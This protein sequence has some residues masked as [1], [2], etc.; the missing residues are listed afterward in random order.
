MADLQSRIAALPAEK[1]ALLERRLAEMA[2]AR[3][4][5]P[6]DR[7]KPR[8]RSKPTP[9][10]IPQEREW[11]VGRFRSANNIPGAFR[12]VGEIDPELLSQVFTE[13]IRRH[14]VLRSTVEIR[15]GGSL[16]QV[17]HP[18]TPVPVPV[19]DLTHLTPEQQAQQVRRRW[20]AEVV[21]RFGPGQPQ[22]LRISLLRMAENNHVA[23]VTTDHAA[24]D[25][26]SV[27]LLI[28]EFAAL[29]GIHAHGGAQSLPP[30]EIQY[31]D[32]AAWQR[33]LGHERMAAE[34][35]FWRRS[36]DGIRD[37]LA[38]P[39]DRPFPARPTFAGDVHVMDLSPELA[40]ELRRFG[41][42][43]KV[44]VGVLLLAA[45]AVLLHRYLDQT[46]LII[47]ELVSGRNRVETERLIGCFNNALPLRIRLNGEQTLREV[48]R[49]VRDVVMSSYDNQDLS[50]ERL[51]GE[52]A[53][54]HDA[55][56]TSMTD[57]WLNV[58]TLP[59]TLEVPGL[60]VSQEPIDVTLTA[61]PLMLEADPGAGALDLRWVY[62]TEMFDTDTVALF[63]E[64]YQR[65]LRQLVT[66]ADIPVGQVELAV[67]EQPSAAADP[68]TDPD[69]AEIGYVELFQRRVALAPHAAA[70]VYDGVATSYGNLN[71]E[72][73]RL[74]H[75]LRTLGIGPEARVGILVDRS[76]RLPCAIL[77]VL[78]AG[79][80]Y[81]PLDPSYPPER[82]AFMLAD[83]GARALITE[84]RLATFLTGAGAALP[85]Q[86]VLLDGPSSRPGAD[87]DHDLPE[88]PEPTSLAYVIY[89][90]GST[91]RP[92]GAMIEHRSLARFARD[93]VSR[94]G[95]GAGDR[96]LQFAS[97]SFDVL[98]EEMFPT[99]LAGGA[100][101]IPA[102]HIISSGA[103]LAD[104]AERG[105]LSVME[106]PTA[107]WHEWVRE[108]DRKG[109][110]L[111]ACLRLV[112]IGGERVLPERLTMWRRSG[113]PLMHVYGLTETTVSST[114][115]L[116]D[117]ADPVADWPNLPIGTPLP[118][119]DLRVLDHRLRRVP[120]GAIGEL[121]IGGVGMARGY[122]G[123]PGLTAQRFVANPEPAWPGRRLYR[124]GDLV[125]QRP[126]GNLEFISRV[127]TQI[128]IRGFRVEPTEIESALDRHPLVAESVVTLHE[129]SPGDRR[130][131]AYVVPRPQAALTSSDLRQQLEQQ[132]PGYMVPSVF[133]ELDALPLN[134][135]G[136][137]DRDRLPAPDGDRLDLGHEYVAPQ[138]PQ[139]QKLADIM[140]SVVGVDKVGIHDNFFEVGGDSIL[141]IQIVVRAQEAG[142]RLSPYDLFEHPTVAALAEAAADT[143]T[144]DAEQGPVSGPVP[145][146]PTQ[147]WLCTAG[148]EK[149]QH[150]NLSA[151]LELRAA[152]EPELLREAVAHL[153]A[154]HDGMRQRFLLSGEKT[155]ARIA[156]PGD[157][158]PL[159]AHDLSGLDEAGQARRIA[160]I[161]AGLQAG[162]DLAV[163][164][165]IRVALLTLGGR[166]PDQLAVVVHRMVAD[167]PSVRILLEDLRTAVA[168][169]VSGDQVVLP[170]KTTSW[171][172]WARRLVK[173]AATPP[174]QAQRGY[175]SELA[176]TPV[177][178]LPSDAV[179]EPGAR[180]VAT[181]R[182]VTAS[183]ESAEAGELLHAAPDA[184]NCRVE[185]LLLAA[186][187]R[188]LSQWSGESLH[189][190]DLERQDRVPIFED[191]DLTRTVGWFSHIHPVLLASEP[192]SPAEKT[193]RAVKETLRAVP[194][195]G[196]G[197]PLLHLGPEPLPDLQAE[198][199]FSYLGEV[200]RPTVGGVAAA[201]EPLGPDQD[202][203]ARLPY[204]IEVQAAIADGELEVRW[205]YSESMHTRETVE[206][207]AGCYLGEL[208]LIHELGR[209]ADGPMYG[210][211]DFPLARVDQAQ[212]DGLLG[213]L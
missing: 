48:V 156:P 133:V 34:H 138:T 21:G 81:L 8:D 17:V 137:V 19:T 76:P 164:P 186:L 142:L 103:E 60:H 89:T 70:V 33:E 67:A 46:D 3:G 72:A 128:R 202:P 153:L 86:T 29:Y 163:G 90:S 98:V 32:F 116:L 144:I 113:V 197:W 5:A 210:P 43:E 181:A 49:N 2:A 55:S 50:V 170:A 18:V 159:E 167:V 123:R 111:P 162:L 65:V 125:R 143:P 57:V 95:L 176:G 150:W 198:L 185:E 108:L 39:S 100:V 179:A 195:S 135:N 106:L 77:A 154:H 208:R 151:L 169:L 16:V 212:L 41:D 168:Q 166:Q 96:F 122:L 82:I 99:W 102:E 10:A 165:L 78:K 44:S 79:G 101:V 53:L 107:Y 182:T 15:D 91:G 71:R 11:A 196:M 183:L 187:T 28:E 73:N 177:G 52:L 40:A 209:S 174:V 31:G 194:S 74:A 7:I 12:V 88:A 114:F 115:F 200:G 14:E 104:L 84:E 134:Q 63:A 184:L 211:S 119:A 13:V 23:L 85:D 172:S 58:Q 121:Y 38:L 92:K 109:R 152:S 45:L 193:V 64:Q 129:P 131:V 27:A 139:Q 61:A 136:K 173:Y 6:A 132:L 94:L 203:C 155:R 147:R 62:M 158:A 117:P 160:E 157:V 175:W 191:V 75:R 68:A 35:E 149:P 93:I 188:T 120:A 69:A 47:G 66:A 189:L 51:V 37:R 130:L 213:R 180:T 36:L 178:R 87:T 126:D 199:V 42:D 118:S 80:A 205:R 140:A 97:P 110:K 141:A 56:L 146:A 30:V 4:P 9:L 22:R 26:A 25:L 171:Q 112:I 24:A 127:D 192:G 59:R 207:L 83:A 105:R 204:A 206:Y 145:L 161:A 54:G 20:Q 201:P 190:V 1:R 124:T 148:L